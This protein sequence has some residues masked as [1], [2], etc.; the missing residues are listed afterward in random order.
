MKLFLGIFFFALSS[1]GNNCQEY[2][3]NWAGTCEGSHS[4]P[5]QLK[6]E[7]VNNC[8]AL[9]FFDEVY[10]INDVTQIAENTKNRIVAHQ[11]VLK[12]WPD[13]TSANKFLVFNLGILNTLGRGGWNLQTDIHDLTLEIKKTGSDLSLQIREITNFNGYRPNNYTCILQ[14]TNKPLSQTRVNEM[15]PSRL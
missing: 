6:I 14:P 1:L 12:W 9:K 11:G 3:G 5:Y 2:I 15:L 13:S 8:Q 10:K 7:N 4:F